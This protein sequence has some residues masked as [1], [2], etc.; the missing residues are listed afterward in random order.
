MA[1]KISVGR[2]FEK[3]TPAPR[4]PSLPDVKILPGNRI[5]ASL[6]VPVRK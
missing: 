5:Q 4:Q 2:S 1:G 3:P 6:A